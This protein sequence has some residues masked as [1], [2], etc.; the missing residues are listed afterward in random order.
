MFA[1]MPTHT[2]CVPRRNSVESKPDRAY[3]AKPAP[4][5]PSRDAIAA[6]RVATGQKNA[7]STG[8]KVAP[9]RRVQAMMFHHAESSARS[10]L[11]TMRT[12]VSSTRATRV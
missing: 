12:T 9:L 4:K 1:I 8:A 2:G 10:M 11:N 7:A 5:P 3:H 6:E